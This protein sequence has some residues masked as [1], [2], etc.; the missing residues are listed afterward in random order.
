[1]VWGTSRW[2]DVRRPVGEL[3]AV[4]ERHAEQLADDGRGQRPGEVVDHVQLAA[5][6]RVVEH[7]IDELLHVRA[8]ALDRGWG[9]GAAHQAP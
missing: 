2:V 9:E 6:L 4:F 3:R 5:L 8:Q 1:M 7:A